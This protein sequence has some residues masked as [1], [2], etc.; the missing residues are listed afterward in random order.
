MNANSILLQKK[1]ARIIELFAKNNNLSIEESLDIFYRSKLYKL[2][3]EGVS[4][5]HCMSDTY[6]ANELEEEYNTINMW[7]H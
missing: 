4:D 5:M 3:S 1:Y 6:L 2:I 7:K